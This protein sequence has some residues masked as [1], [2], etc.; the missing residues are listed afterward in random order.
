MEG[1]GGERGRGGEEG[2]GGEGRWAAVFALKNSHSE[3]AHIRY[4]YIPPPCYKVLSQV[5]HLVDGREV[6]GG[7]GHHTVI[8]RGSLVPLEDRTAGK[9]GGVGW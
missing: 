5:H 3:R 9:R 7:V 2:R 1:R 8:S 4:P 6:E